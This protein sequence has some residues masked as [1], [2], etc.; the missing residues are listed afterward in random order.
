LPGCPAPFYNPPVRKTAV[1]SVCLL[2]PALAFAAV[3]GRPAPGVSEVIVVF[4]T[5]FDIGYTD[6][7]RAIVQR[8]RTTMIDQALDVVDRNRALPPDRRFVWT[9]PGWPLAQIAGDWAGQTSERMKRV[10][11]AFREGRFVVHALPFT[12]H[13]ELL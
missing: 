2:L 6:M 7:A 13:T 3:S 1:L 5:H 12:M 11:A 10:E 8:Y 4:K 9:L